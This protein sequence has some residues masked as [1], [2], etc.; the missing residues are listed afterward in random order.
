MKTGTLR[1]P[2]AELFHE[3]RGRGPMLLLVPGGGGDAGTFDGI[4][5]VLARDFTVVAADPRGYRRCGPAL[6]PPGRW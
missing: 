6:Q 3:V 2:G 4:A 5:E 1:V